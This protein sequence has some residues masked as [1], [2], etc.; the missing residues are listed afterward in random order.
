MGRQS[1]ML[2]SVAIVWGISGNAQDPGGGGSGGAAPPDSDNDTVSDVS[3]DCPHTYGTSPNGCPTPDDVEEVVV[4]GTH[5]VEI[6]PWRGR[7][8]V[9]THPSAAW[10]SLCSGYSGWT[11]GIWTPGGQWVANA[12]STPLCGDGLNSVYCSCPAGKAKRYAAGPGAGYIYCVDVA[13]PPPDGKS[14]FVNIP[15]M[16]GTTMHIQH[17][18]GVFVDGHCTVVPPTCDELA[19]TSWASSLLSGGTG[20]VFASKTAGVLSILNGTWGTV[21]TLDLT[22]LCDNNEALIDAIMELQREHRASQQGG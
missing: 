18:L 10:S 2:A 13:P 7:T 9:C 6:R 4:H 16:V 8:I 14:C 21:A 12:P 1:I 11:P 17:R 20:I 5:V 22:G 19:I 3:D 15:Y